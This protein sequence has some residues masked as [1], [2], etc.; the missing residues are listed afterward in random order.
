V[1]VF[2]RS[3]KKKSN[4]DEDSESS[5]PESS[6]N[7]EVDERPLESSSNSVPK[8][9]EKVESLETKTASISVSQ[10]AATILP[11]ETADGSRTAEEITSFVSECV[12]KN[13]IQTLL[14]WFKPE[15]VNRIVIS[16]VKTFA[17]AVGSSTQ[18]NSVCSD[19]EVLVKTTTLVKINCRSCG[20]TAF[21]GNYEDILERKFLINHLCSDEPSAAELLASI[22]LCILFDEVA[23]FGSSADTQLPGSNSTTF[24]LQLDIDIFQSLGNSLRAQLD[25]RHAL[26]NTAADISTM[27]RKR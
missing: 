4:R 3:L 1:Q 17:S 19:R 11:S 26:T 6:E 16:A 20:I 10:F 9:E 8:K 18:Q 15:L 14:Q 25:I 23:S 7:I 2:S 27:V 13:E 5:Y 21:S 24:A 12:E 22:P